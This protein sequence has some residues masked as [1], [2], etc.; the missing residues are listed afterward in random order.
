LWIVLTAAWITT[1]AGIERPDKQFALAR[2]PIEISWSQEPYGVQI[3]EFPVEI[4]QGTIAK[5][6]NNWIAE[7]NVI[8]EKLAQA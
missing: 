6:I 5:A 1:I 4:D 7:L 2:Q 3:L 8:L